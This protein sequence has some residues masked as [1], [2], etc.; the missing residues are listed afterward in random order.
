MQLWLYLAFRTWWTMQ[1]KCTMECPKCCVCVCEECCKHRFVASH[2][3]IVLRNRPQPICVSDNTFALPVQTVVKFRCLTNRTMKNS[4]RILWKKF[5]D[6]SARD[7]KFVLLPTFLISRYN[8]QVTD[9]AT[10][11]SWFYSWQ[12][13]E[14]FLFQ[15]SRTALRPTQIS[16]QWVSA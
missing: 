14:I 2:P 8:D 10:D 5:L 3:G 11:E 1:W 16:G 9:R 4:R 6:L 15:T 13:Q 12:R 7:L